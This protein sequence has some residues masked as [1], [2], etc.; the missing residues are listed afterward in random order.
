MK[1]KLSRRE[2]ALVAHARRRAVA[3]YKSSTVLT[4]EVPNGGKENKPVE[5]RQMTLQHIEL[6][7]VILYGKPA[8]F[9]TLTPQ[10]RQ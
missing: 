8:M 9:V 7:S 6:T 10:W 3:E 1:Q 2:A 4:I 5:L